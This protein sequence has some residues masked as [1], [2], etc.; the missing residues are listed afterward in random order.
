MGTPVKFYK[1]T[2]AELQEKEPDAKKVDIYM[3][4]GKL[5]FIEDKNEG[6]SFESIDKFE[7]IKKGDEFIL[8]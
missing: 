6:N 7:V 3:K 2:L 8:K 4:D 5:F 1:C